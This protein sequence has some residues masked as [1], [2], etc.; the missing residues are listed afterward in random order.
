M[1]RWMGSIVQR[2]EMESWVYHQ[3]KGIETGEWSIRHEWFYR[4]ILDCK[5]GNEH[6]AQ[7]YKIRCT[8][9]WKMVA[10]AVNE[11]TVMIAGELIQGA[12]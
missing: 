9:I 3:N 10:D 4:W 12:Y 6:K 7:G 1:F 11:A 8:P 5:K 2:Q